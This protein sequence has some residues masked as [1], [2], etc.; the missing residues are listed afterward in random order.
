MLSRK[1]ILLFTKGN[2]FPDFLFASLALPNGLIHKEFAAR[3]ANSFL[4]E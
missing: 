1:K 4:Y 3:G 2:N